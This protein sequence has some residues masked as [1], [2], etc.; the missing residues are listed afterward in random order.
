[1]YVSTLKCTQDAYCV[2]LMGM[3]QQHQWLCGCNWGE[4]YLIP[5]W[6]GRHQVCESKGWHR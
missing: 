1:M 6:L 4:A 2:V 3:L 5:T